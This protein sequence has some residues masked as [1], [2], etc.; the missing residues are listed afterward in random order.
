MELEYV[1]PRI[2]FETVVGSRAYGIHT[3]ESD[4]D[5]SGVMIPGPEYFLGFEKFEQFEGFPEK[6]RKV[7]DIRKALKLI[8]DNN[9]NMMDLLFMPERCVV[10]ST[11]YWDK[12]LE[13]R[14]WFVSKKARYTFSGY[15]IAQLKRIKT[16][17]KF[18]IDP[19]KEAPT[20]ENYGLEPESIFPTS[21]LKAVVY[22]ALEFIQESEKENLIAELDSIYGDYVIPLFARFLKPDQHAVAMD[23]LQLGIKGQAKA[24]L[25]LGTQYIK[26]EYLDQA[27][28]EV[29]FYDAQADWKRYMQWKKSRNKARAVLEEKYSFDCKHAAHLVRL[30]RMGV[31]VLKTGKINVDRTNIDA[32]ELKAIRVGAWKFEE[33][34]EYANEMDKKMDA[35]YKESNL[36]KEPQRKKIADLCVEIS[37]EYLYNEKSISSI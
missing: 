13:H 31:E 23:W 5:R 25:S 30:M 12:V 26:D 33:V 21:Q 34:E 14:D 1:L 4:Y 8:M 3:P 11:P 16:H 17:R 2:I 18:L 19:P 37:Q 29:A 36:Q 6:D 10:T 24:F 20:R 7:Y 22:A 15:A 32:E 27:S 28:K 9:P 35:L